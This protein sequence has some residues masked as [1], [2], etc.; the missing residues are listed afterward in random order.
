[1]KPLIVAFVLLCGL[2]GA[3]NASAQPLSCTVSSTGV[4]FG[5]Y[6]VFSGSSLDSTGNISFSCTKNNVNVTIT[7]NTGGS[8]IFS[9]RRMGGPDSLDY[10]LY[11]DAARSTIWGDGTSGTS[12]HMQSSGP[13]D[14]TNNVTVYGRVFAGQDV[15]A[16]SYGDSITVTIFF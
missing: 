11:T 9:P 5:S 2:A 6:D 1:M 8:G 10:N 15:S 16:G 3:S 4:S 13:K 7:L 14:S 12:P